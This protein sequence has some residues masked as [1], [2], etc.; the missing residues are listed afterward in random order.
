MESGYNERKEQELRSSELASMMNLTINYFHISRPVIQ[1]SSR[2]KNIGAHHDVL[3]CIINARRRLGH[4]RAL[5]PVGST[6]TYR[7]CLNKSIR[8]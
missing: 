6:T 4:V 3:L 5:V 7:S 1:T 8:M 2:A